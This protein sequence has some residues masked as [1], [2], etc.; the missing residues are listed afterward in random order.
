[1]SIFRAIAEINS[2]HN[3]QQVFGVQ[4]ITS[5]RM[6]RDIR[7]WYS[8][9]YGED[10][11]EQEDGCQ[12]IPVAVVQKLSKAVFSEYSANTTLQGTAGEAITDT[13]QGLENVRRRAM[14]QMLIGGTAFIKPIIGEKIRFAVIS[15]RNFAPFGRDADGNINDIG[16]M[17]RT[18]QDG[19]VY[20]LLERRHIDE[21]GCLIISSRLFRSRDEGSLGENVPL[22]TLPKYADLIP[23]NRLPEPMHSLGLIALRCPIEN[24]VDGSPD[25]VSVYAPAVGLI[26]NINR[27]EALL[28][29]EFENGRSRII[30]SSDMINTDEE[31]RRNLDADLF[32]GVDEDVSNVGI[33]V[34]S[35]ALRD[36]NYLNR[37]TEYLRNVESLIGF[38]RGVLSDVEETQKTATEITSSAGE[39]SLTVQDFQ[40]QWEK[41]LRETVRVCAILGKMYG[42]WNAGEIDPENDIAVNWGNGI[43][44]DEDKEWS[45]LMSLVSGGYLKP[46]IA[47]A[48]K[49]DLPWDTPEDLNAI[50][51][52]YMPQETQEAVIEE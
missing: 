32:V 48:W 49:Y 28:N 43:L 30:A 42:I 2:F 22:D 52:K 27:N 18:T 41:C 37:K 47:I 6:H 13:L 20:T 23:E 46:E 50:R 39:Y 51:E 31:G 3:F 44:Y 5:A 34:F 14:Q 33:T 1:M 17:E 19:F 25:A 45:T 36:E 10:L 4:D 21:D 12:R 7:E 8:L 35:P 26:H 38:K 40:Q 16:T 29:Q 11:P 15:R 24:T 9:Y